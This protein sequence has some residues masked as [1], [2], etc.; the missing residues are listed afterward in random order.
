MPIIGS[1]LS[2]RAFGGIGASGG[3]YSLGDSAGVEF[4]V[5]S[6][7]GYNHTTYSWTVPAGVT[8]VSIVV[9]ASGA[10]GGAGGGGA[11]RGSGGGGG[12]V[13][14]RNGLSVTPGEVLTISVGRGGPGAM[15]PSDPPNQT[16][17]GSSGLY[18]RVER[19]STTLVTANGGSFGY[20]SSYNSVGAGGTG[21]STLSG[22]YGGGTGGN[23]G[24]GGSSNG[25]GG[26]AGLYTGGTASLGSAVGGDGRD[27]FGGT[28]GPPTW[29]DGEDYGGGG[30]GSNQMSGSGGDGRVRI[31]WD[32]SNTRSF[33]STRTARSFSAD[34]EW[35][36]TSGQSGP[37]DGSYQSPTTSY[38][39]GEGLYNFT[40]G[41]WRNA[42]DS[43]TSNPQIWMRANNT[44]NSTDAVAVRNA[45]DQQ[46]VGDIIEI[47][48][49][50]SGNPTP[51]AGKTFTITG[52]ISKVVSGNYDNW[53]WD[54]GTEGLTN[55]QYFYRF[56]VYA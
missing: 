22:N 2:V 50:S 35:I 51:V 3:L 47:L 54:V 44:D 18:A 20:G 12:G 28:T 33:P 45:L 40:H 43:S 7:V 31:I 41:Q 52:G 53:Y 9:I 34:G 11:A 10:S 17:N 23:G 26:D 29:I 37:G 46:Q 39:A 38:T 49:T 4:A 48:D 1:A 42:T 15:V 27:V 8:S 19:G 25:G 30:A 16:A 36:Y 24:T 14:Y 6:S 13:S 56:T 21:G 5:D 55:S 32:N